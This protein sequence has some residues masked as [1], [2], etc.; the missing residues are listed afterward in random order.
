MAGGSASSHAGSVDAGSVDAGA[1][2]AGASAPAPTATPSAVDILASMTL[3]QK[4]AQLFVVTP[5]QLVCRKEPV[6]DAGPLTRAALQERPVGGLIFFGRNI[7]DP[8]HFSELVHGCARLSR[9]AGVGVEAFRMVD[10]EGGTVARIAKSG[11]FDVPTF[12]DMAQIGATHDPARARE[13]GQAVGTYLARLGFNVDLAP[14]A[15]V[16]VNPRNKII[17]SRSFGSDPKLVATM[18]VDEA[19]AM[20]EMGVL[21]CAKHFPGHGGTTTDSH[22]GAATLD[23][24]KDEL[25]TCEFLPFWAFSFFRLPLIMVGHI[26]TPRAAADGLPASLSPTVIDGWLRGELGFSGVVISDALDM[27]AITQDFGSAEAAVRFIE[28]GGDLAL[29]PQR[30]DRAYQGILDAV[31]AGRLT[32]ARIDQSVLRILAIKGYA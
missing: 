21:P 14:V 11:A 20:R 4:V 26:Q 5:E 32:E 15:D 27:G 1:V 28:A 2:D 29:M 25:R 12:P 16:L 9:Q 19:R 3:E 13:L 18:A 6:L 22:E 23:R 17:G 8:A 30:F 24:T 31:A 7:S 10:E